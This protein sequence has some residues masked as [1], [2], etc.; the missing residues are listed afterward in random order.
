MYVSVGYLGCPVNNNNNKQIKKI[1]DFFFVIIKISEG[2]KL[3]DPSQCGSCVVR[4][5]RVTRQHEFS[6]F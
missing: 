5:R 1:H 4:V 6:T 2:R 3:I